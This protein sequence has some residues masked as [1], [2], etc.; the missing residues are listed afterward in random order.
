V[1]GIL[2]LILLLASGCGTTISH[3]TTTGSGGTSAGS[4]AVSTGAQL[5]LVW[6]SSDSTL[7]A[8]YGV[9]GATQL[10]AALFP[11]GTYV[12]GSFSAQSQTALLI[13]PKGNLDRM[14]L[15]SLTPQII[16]QQIPT[17]ASI[18]FSPKG[19]Y[20][21]VYAAGSASLL[22]LSGLPQQP[23]LQTVSSPAA[24]LGATMSDD[25]TLLLATSAGNGHAS[26]TSAAPG[27][28]RTTLATLQGYGGM[29][30]LPGSQDFVLSDSVANTLALVHNGS[31]TVLATH[32]SGLNQPFAVAVSQDDR[33]A[34]AADHADANLLRI[35]L[36][37]AT[38]P[39]QSTCA[40]S[41]NQLAAL[42]GNAVFELKGPGAG[43]GWMIEADDP[44]ARVLF[45]PPVRSGQ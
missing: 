13:D 14:T 6:N 8:L 11:A 7:R 24:L 12:S 29:A 20:A 36:T 33:W 44:I 23:T 5:G 17:G 27:G 38:P 26:I 1:S 4:S 41:P 19:A 39:S 43:P 10:G 32:A 31:P 3:S 16:A 28:A 22:T 2:C 15:P 30:F 45:I 40:C 35:D 9:P 18:G 21:V 34:V 25:G 42:Y 37:G